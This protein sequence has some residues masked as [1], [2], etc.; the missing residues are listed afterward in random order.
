M[1]ITKHEIGNIEWSLCR[2]REEEESSSV[3]LTEPRRSCL[4]L[5]RA[6]NP[7]RGTDL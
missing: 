1:K 4:S 6:W 3:L 2:E 7:E 5:V